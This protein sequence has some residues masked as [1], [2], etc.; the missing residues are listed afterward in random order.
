MD[1]RMK[2]GFVEEVLLELTFRNKSNGVTGNP[3]LVSIE[4]AEE[5]GGSEVKSKHR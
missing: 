4:S 5:I 2:E 3:R 1:S